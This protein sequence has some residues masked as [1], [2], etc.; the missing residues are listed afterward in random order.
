MAKR[1]TTWVGGG[2]LKIPETDAGTTPSEVIQLIP[3]QPLTEQ[4]G[5]RTKCVIDAIYLHFSIRRILNSN[6]DALG[7]IVYQGQVNETA[8]NPVQSLDALSLAPRAYANKNI[9]MMAPLPIPP[10][11]GA[12]DLASFTTNEA[13]LVAHHEFQA[14]RKHDM[15]S[16]VLCLNVNCDISLVLRVF[17]QWRILLAWT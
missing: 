9:M 8:D 12:G 1:R 4:A 2:Q 5:D 16:Q 10:L 7:F 11:L 6:P 14:S 15:A 3:S 13:V 17:C